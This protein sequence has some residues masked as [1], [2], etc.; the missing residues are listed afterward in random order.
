MIASLLGADIGVVQQKVRQKNAQLEDLH[1]RVLRLS[2]SLH[3]ASPDKAFATTK[4]KL[5][6]DIRN[7]Q[8]DGQSCQSCGKQLLLGMIPQHAGNCRGEAASPLLPS[9]RPPSN[10]SSHRTRGA[11]S[12]AADWL[13]PVALP[14]IRSEPILPRF[15]S[16]PPRN[17]RVVEDGIDHHSILLEWDPPIFTGSNPITDY[18]LRCGVRQT[19][20][21]AT[22]QQVSI[23]T[24]SPLL[25]SR[26]CLHIP[27]APNQFCLD[28]LVAAQEYCDFALC[29]IT[30]NGKSES[31]NRIDVVKTAPSIEPTRPLFLSAGAV[32]ATTIT[33]SWIEPHDSGGKPIVD[34]DISFIEAVLEDKDASRF[35]DGF[36]NVADVAYRPK[37]VRTYSAST[38][39]TMTNL[40]SGKEHKQFRVR[41]VN[42]DGK[43]GE[44]SEPIESIFTI[45]T[46][47]SV[48]VMLDVWLRLT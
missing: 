17:L 10:Q 25:T 15:V 46:H 1:R 12:L 37:R 19:S 31:S 8:L 43:P 13:S 22:D 38:T 21:R 48:V 47:T 36:L 7:Q 11:N 4:L 40:L 23:E 29:A 42:A 2:M 45:G 33:L 34:Y 20:G 5:E 14:S 27:V 44:F 35:E 18:E 26:W 9:L 24:L 41:A 30:I 3:D 39:F 32:T 16:Q 28:G 6:E